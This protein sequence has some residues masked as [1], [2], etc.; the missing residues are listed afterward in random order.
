[1][2]V[3]I[4]SDSA[5]GPDFENILAHQANDAIAQGADP[6]Q[7]TTRLGTA[8]RWLRA[9]PSAIDQ[10]HAALSQGADPKA[11]SGRIW[12]VAQ[13]SSRPSPHDT[14]GNIDLRGGT[15]PAVPVE[16]S[17][18]LDRAGSA[19]KGTLN[20]LV[21]H[22]LDTIGSI[23][24]AP[25]RSAVGLLDT[26][27]VGEEVSPARANF[28]KGGNLLGA[29]SYRAPPKGTI[30]AQNTPNAESLADLNAA[31]AQTVANIGAG[32][33]AG[34][35]TEAASPIVGRLAGRVLGSTATGATIGAAYDPRDPGVGAVAGGVAGT[36]LHPVGAVVEGGVR[37]LLP[38]S[39]APENATANRSTAIVLKKLGQDQVTPQDVAARVADANG[40][41]V[42]IADV[43]GPNTRE[44]LATA[45][46]V[47]SPGKQQILDAMQL[48][49]EAQGQR[50]S[51]DLESSLGMQQQDVHAIKDQLIQ[52]RRETARP[53]YE[54]AFAGAGPIDDPTV[55]R[56]LAT[57]AGKQAYQQALVDAA[58]NFHDLPA[59]HRQIQ[60]PSSV[61]DANGKPL[62]V[63]D[64]E[65]TKA[66]DLRTLDYVKKVLDRHGRWGDVLPSG[67][68]ASTD[69]ATAR[70]LSYQLADALDKKVPAYRTARQQFA[71]DVALQDAFEGGQDFLTN[72]ARLTAKQ[73]REMSP[74]E[75]EMYRISVLDALRRTIDKTPDGA[76]AVRRIFGN[77]ERR[78]QLQTLI[79][80][81]T[82]FGRLQ[83]SLG[84]ESGMTR[85][86][87]AV[88]GNSATDARRVASEEFAAD[89]GGN[90][91][92]VAGAVRHPVR[93]AIA[94]AADKVNQVRQGLVGKTASAVAGKL[95]A[96][97]SGN[98]ADLQ[99]VIQ[100][101]ID[102]T[103]RRR[104]GRLIIPRA[105]G[106]AT[107]NQDQ[108]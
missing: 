61:L 55:T 21:S 37:K 71:G 107:A 8:I 87:A 69:A 50:I 98:S 42:T 86:R 48:R 44:L 41:P 92:D 73:L 62:L 17:G 82:A 39:I 58:N 9:N 68:T 32:K 1:M 13:S 22:P 79:G 57:P 10:A 105:A 106:I 14:P 20:Q 96:G 100:Q 51:G 85:T 40:K 88:T 4:R 77:T 43:A 36:V 103:Q 63:D 83:Q 67:G 101:L 47:P 76:D 53:L 102:A 46:R 81:P 97:A 29:S 35:V 90:S 91:V 25:V 66:P 75:Q 93:Y 24:A 84:I 78:N 2:T 60:R 52:S 23:V 5:Q 72:D 15:T 28:G 16:Q 49:H 19:I 94:K 54:K 56:I 59:I 12:Q 89:A 30:T 74:G 64:I 26:P 34:A 3:P 95:T 99:A 11:V 70:S 104:S 65:Y 80:D 33:V 31:G 7:V 6:R 108:P 38:A 45:S 27:V 18:F